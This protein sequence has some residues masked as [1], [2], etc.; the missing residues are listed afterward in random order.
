MRVKVFL[1]PKT[2]QGSCAVISAVLVIGVTLAGCSER[3]A[4]VRAIPPSPQP[5]GSNETPVELADT[6][7]PATLS[8][9]STSSSVESAIPPSDSTTPSSN[10]EESEFDRRLRQLEFEAVQKSTQLTNERKNEAIDPALFDELNQAEIPYDFGI[11]ESREEKLRATKSDLP[12]VLNKQV[13]RLI[14]YFT[15]RRGLKTFKRTMERGSAYRDMIE[16]ILEEEDVPSEMFHLAQAESG[17]RPKAI[18]RARAK[19]MWQFVS[20][21]G[22]QY[23]LRGNRYLEERYDAELAT[24]AAARHLK[25][26][27]IE[28]GDWYLVMAAYNGGPNRVRRGIKTSG[29]RDYWE[30][31]RR[32]LLRRET[33]NYVPI[34]LAMTYVAKNRWLYESTEFDWVKPIRY[35]TVQVE[36]EIHIDL[37]AEIAGTSPNVIKN[38]NPALLRSATPP[39]SYN[40]R[41]P[42][43]SGPLFEVGIGLIPPEKRLAWRWYRV[44]TGD[45][46]AQLARKF[47]VNQAEIVSANR[48]PSKLISSGIGLAIPGSNRPVKYYYSSGAGGFLVGGSGRYRI[49]RGDTLGGIARR[50]STSV[51]KLKQWNALS[52]SRIIAG[53]YLIVAPEGLKSR[54]AQR[55]RVTTKGG[56]TIGGANKY[57]IRRGDNLS[58]IA[59]R[60]GVTIGQLRD[61]NDLFGSRIHTGRYLNVRD[62]STR[63]TVNQASGS[64]NSTAKSA[65]KPFLGTSYRIRSGDTLSGIADRFG[66]TTT[67]LK[68]WN[69]LHSSRIHAGKDLVVRASIV[70][71]AK[72]PEGPVAL[73]APSPGDAPLR[74]SNVEYEIRPGDTLGAIARRFGVTV[75]QLKQWNRLR[76]SRI[77]VGKTLSIRP[78]GFKTPATLASTGNRIRYKIQPGDTLATIAQRF[79][80]TVSEL[81]AWNG[82][83]TSRIRAGKHLTIYSTVDPRV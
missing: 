34:I 66:V 4:A 29:S 76:T 21:R 24:R 41:L 52:S 63:A 40:L 12:L 71:P 77:R 58:V 16:R 65:A 74:V 47:K 43:G 57:K 8:D 50:F 49:A 45:T 72:N 26:L 27:H 36:S 70:A 9:T 39:M 46:L 37:I 61:W 38:L 80:V 81:K 51:T 5:V 2:P 33:R 18:S 69:G 17:F 78:S 79:G 44:E 35:D 28:F 73:V 1:T 56:S 83:R 64:G 31:S 15:S 22:K 82:L 3:Q 25:D 14:N 67:E 20:F 53:R 62:P 23:G 75:Q 68:K 7:N 30:L 59:K 13:T 10:R 6:A 11:A 60:F 48:L 55:R 19:G 54:Q 42:Q 32:R